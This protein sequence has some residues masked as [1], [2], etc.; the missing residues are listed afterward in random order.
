MDADTN[1]R[2]MATDLQYTALLAKIGS[3]DLH[4][5]EAKY[6]MACLTKLRNTHRS[7]NREQQEISSCNTEEKKIEARAL[8]ELF[9]YI[10][11]SIEGVLC[12]KVSELRCL[13]QTRLADFGSSKEI[14]KVRFKELL[15]SYFPD[16]QAQ[17]DGKN[18]LLIFKQGMQDILKQAFLQKVEDDALIYYAKLPKSSE[19]TCSTSNVSNSVVLYH[20]IANKILSQQ[21]LDI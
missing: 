11:T 14:N 4:A 7:L 1:V 10:E 15:L 19:M 9:S 2:R 17:N 3:G 13:Y 18:I 16:A 21:T 20:L 6:H 12:F 8:T 5:L